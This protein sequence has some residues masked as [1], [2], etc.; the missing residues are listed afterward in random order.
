LA[1]ALKPS[2]QRGATGSAPMMTSKAVPF[3]SPN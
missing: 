2:R 1:L 3:T